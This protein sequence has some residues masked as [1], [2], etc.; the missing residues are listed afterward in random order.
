[1]QCN[2]NGSSDV[3]FDF[4]IVNYNPIKWPPR[5]AFSYDWTELSLVYSRNIWLSRRATNK[6]LTMKVCKR[7][8]VGCVTWRVDFLEPNVF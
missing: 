5:L 6:N 7:S 3:Q 4:F 8:I 2:K 1:M